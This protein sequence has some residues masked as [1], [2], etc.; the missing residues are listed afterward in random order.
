[1]AKPQ[2]QAPL[3][4]RR[5]PMKRIIYPIL[6]ILLLLIVGG[7]SDS[8]QIPC[9]NP[10][11][12]ECLD[13]E[14]CDDCVEKGVD[15]ET[16][17]GKVLQ[18]HYNSSKRELALVPELSGS[19]ETLRERYDV[20]Y[21]DQP[22]LYVPRAIVPE[23]YYMRNAKLGL[24]NINDNLLAVTT[25]HPFCRTWNSTPWPRFWGNR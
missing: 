19:E 16:V 14:Y 25:L 17:C 9:E 20:S 11:V 22:F 18:S 4:L 1:M 24:L 13:T 21:S 5:T 10:S 12:S 6:A 7:C 2:A 15:I 23:A 8:S 3:F